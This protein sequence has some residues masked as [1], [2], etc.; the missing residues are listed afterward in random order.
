MFQSGIKIPA[1]AGQ[2][3]WRIRRATE[4]DSAA[5]ARF[6]EGL[7]RPARSDSITSEYFIAESLESIIGCAAVRAR[8]QFGY[9]YGLAVDK[10]WRRQGIGYSLTQRRL[11]WLRARGVES[12]F[13]CAMFW[14]IRF[15]KR[16]EFKLADRKRRVELVSLHQ[17]FTEHW[18]SH[19]ALLE[20][21]LLTQVKPS[22][23]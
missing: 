4:N 21:D 23:L 10:A 16:H 7:R 1:G 18:N 9:L 12:A 17:D 3:R 13:V 2:N 19:S 15:F 22:S 5:I 11:D 8:E 14:N 20:A 6:H